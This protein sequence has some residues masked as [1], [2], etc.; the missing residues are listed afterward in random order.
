M[1]LTP[2]QR[3]VLLALIDLYYRSKGDAV[4]GE[5][6]ASLV[7][8]NPGTIRNQMQAL[9]SLG[10]VE[11]VP[12]PKGGYR[13]TTEGYSILNI[14][15]LEEKVHVPIWV[16]KSI[17]E[18]LTVT[19]IDL[20]SIPDPEKCR[21][22][23]HCIGNLK[24]L[25]VGKTVRIGPT[26]VNN[27]MMRGKVIGRDDID[28]VLLIDILEMMSIPK[29]KVLEIASKKITFISPEAPL[30][31]AAKILLRERIRGAPVVK[32]GKPI[33]II[34]TVDITKALAEG[35]VDQKVKE[36]MSTEIHT[37]PG[38]DCLSSAIEKMENYNISRLIVIDGKGRAKG[39]ITRTDILC[40]MANLCR[41]IPSAA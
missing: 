38:D 20:I 23:V 2:V 11:G 4:K 33:G 35:K 12:G 6:I 5:E 3:E 24:K 7:K 34:S 27:L 37:I 18:G 1:K 30:R 40:R 15:E 36:V 14:K 16:G 41:S 25:P 32:K 13:P 21:A 10:L 19:G 26:P 22:T 8:K 29:E 9:R 39:I 28:N 17:L 31:R